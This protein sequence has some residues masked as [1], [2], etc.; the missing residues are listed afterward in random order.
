ML[1]KLTAA[2]ALT[3]LMVGLAYAGGPAQ[4]GINGSMHDMNA[5]AGTTKDVNGRTCV[6]CHT[7]HNAQTALY[8]NNDV[9]APLWNRGD[10]A[11]NATPYA[12]AT[13]A[14]NSIDGINYSIP[15]LDPLIGPTRLC[16]SCHDGSIAFDSHAPNSPD[17]GLKMG[18]ANHAFINDL[19]VT[20][21]IG[22]KYSDAVAARGLTELIPA[23]DGFLSAPST[24]F[25][26]G[27]FNTKSRGGLA[28]TT[29]KIADVLY[30]GADGGDYMT[31]ATC[32]DVHNTSNAKSDTGKSYNYFLRARQ[33]GS[34]ICLSC[35]IK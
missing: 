26:A 27:T 34:A 14:N 31:C 11:L 33:E 32:H 2:I 3:G 23:S 10:T 4:T 29:M 1:R 6:F 20:H 25:S 5:I 16:L 30:T 18:T 17:I 22:F 7:P 35:H 15:I 24:S 12:W 19:T 13:P 9:K 28:K 8:T 21:P